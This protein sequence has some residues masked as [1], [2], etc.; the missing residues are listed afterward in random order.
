M[1]AILAMVSSLAAQLAQAA[2]LNSTLLVDRSRRKPTESYLFVGR[3]ADHHDLDAIH[4]IAS[5]ALSQLIQLKPSFRDYEDILFSDS[6][7]GVDRTLLPGLAGKELS[8][9]LG[10]FLP[11]LGVYLTETPTSKVLEWLVRRFRH[12]YYNLAA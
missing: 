6:A 12:V 9:N 1:T 7:K 2:S 8:K 10:N 4:A 11:L 3:E 5:S